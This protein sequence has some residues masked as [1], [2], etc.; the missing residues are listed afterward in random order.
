MRLV[1]PEQEALL[2]SFSDPTDFVKTYLDVYR[3]QISVPV[4]V[5]LDDIPYYQVFE[6]E[7]LDAV[8]RQ[9]LSSPVDFGEI[10]AMMCSVERERF[11]DRRFHSESTLILIKGIA[12][13]VDRVDQEVQRQDFSGVRHL[14]HY[15]AEPVDLTLVL[16]VQCS[17]C[18][19]N[20]QQLV[21]R[22]GELRS[23]V[24]FVNAQL[25]DVGRS[26]FAEDKRLRDRMSLSENVLGRERRERYEMGDVYQSVFDLV[27]VAA[28]AMDVSEGYVYIMEF[29]SEFVTVGLGSEDVVEGL[30][31]HAGAMLG[32]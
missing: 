11:Y 8:L 19:R 15:T 25:E 17:R 24:E 14:F 13:L 6:S 27:A 22:I 30:K 31:R 1:L 5:Y 21:G 16:T 10:E 4:K 29:C 2:R 9:S 20:P 18:I 12:V 28:D 7:F 26:A 3:K 32:E 23:A